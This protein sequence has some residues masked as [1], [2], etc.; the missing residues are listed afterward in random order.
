MNQLL[1]DKPMFSPEGNQS[2]NLSSRRGMQPE[3]TTNQRRQNVGNLVE[4]LGKRRRNVAI[5]VVG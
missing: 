3:G 2:R 1:V 5:V 4:V